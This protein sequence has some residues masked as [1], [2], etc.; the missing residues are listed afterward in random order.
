MAL[1]ATALCADRL[2]TAEPGFRPQQM[3]QFARQLATRLT[4]SFRRVVPAARLDQPRQDVQEGQPVLRLAASLP[5]IA[6]PAAFCP[7]QFR[8]PPPRA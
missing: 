8:L 5:A 7:F 3:A 6:H 1:V 2:A 4:V